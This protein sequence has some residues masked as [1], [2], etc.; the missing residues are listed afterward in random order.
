MD[1]PATALGSEWL[2]FHHV[3]HAGNQDRLL[4]ELVRPAVRS[5]WQEGRIESFF[6]LRH[7]LGG[8]HIRLRIRPSPGHRDGVRE[9]VRESAASYFSQ[10][11]SPTR[12][13]GGAVSGREE[14][15]QHQEP[16][17]REQ[18][19]LEDNSIQEIPF[20][21]E[22][23]RYGGLERIGKSLDFFALS[24]ARALRLLD[25]R[26]TVSAGE[27]LTIVLRLEARHILGFAGDVPE[28]ES[29]VA[30]PQAAP[31]RGADLIRERADRAFAE[32]GDRLVRLL[33]GE[34][35]NLGVAALSPLEDGEVARRLR[36][37][38]ADAPLATRARILTSQVHMTANRLGLANAEEA[39]VA[40]ILWR[41]FSRLQE[42][43]AATWS[44]LGDLLGC[45]A[46]RDSSPARRLEDLLAP[47][48]ATL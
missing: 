38:L 29:L 16:D 6:F 19:I 15:L 22:I 30:E 21:P 3:N 20:E 41:T 35:E 33:R 44:D 5:L 9:A 48:F 47:A 28:L 42:V 43:D 31:G 11:P 8:P 46:T 25:H 32:S 36:R 27:W 34:I 12:V 2:S 24:S 13:G 23:E 7:V 37:E 26:P 18:G 40:R 17:G 10:I 39:Y 4:T 1:S 14:S 45:R